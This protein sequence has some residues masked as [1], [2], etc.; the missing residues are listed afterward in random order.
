MDV[1]KLLE[2]IKALFENADPFRTWWPF[3]VAAAVFLGTVIKAYMSGQN[4]PNSNMVN[5]LVILIT[6][7]DG[8]E[9]WLGEKYKNVELRILNLFNY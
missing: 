7:A 9:L 6:G 8:G 3:A 5:D 1:E 2:D 4:C